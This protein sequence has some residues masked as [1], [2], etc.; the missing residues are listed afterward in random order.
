MA[1]NAA[2]MAEVGEFALHASA[3]VADVRAFP[4]AFLITHVDTYAGIIPRIRP[5]PFAATPAAT[6]P[7]TKASAPPASDQQIVVVR[8]VFDV[9]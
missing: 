3:A 6:N 8:I 7:L 5:V 9:I 1:M 4:A 2:A